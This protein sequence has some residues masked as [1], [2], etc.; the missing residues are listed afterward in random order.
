MGPRVQH[1]DRPAQIQA[2][3]GPIG[4]G[5]VWTEPKPLRRVTGPQ[6]DDGI[7]LASR[8]CRHLR[9]QAAVR[10]T[11]L[12]RAIGL[13][14]GLVALLVYRAVVPAA[15]KREVRKRCGATLR[16]MVEMMPLDDS[17]AAAGESTASVPML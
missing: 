17:D 11:E 8:R 6:G 16:P 4:V 5:R 3:A 12:E 1:V 15:K 2:L 10:P 7:P 14:R 9:K 13:T